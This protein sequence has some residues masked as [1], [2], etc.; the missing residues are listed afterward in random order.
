MVH[1]RNTTPLRVKLFGLAT[2]VGL[3]GGCDEWEN[4]MKT[5]KVTPQYR[6][7]PDS[8]KQLIS[9]IST[10]SSNGNPL[11]LERG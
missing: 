11:S 6:A 10:A 1:R 7:Q 9:Y 8:A 5:E 3:L 4:V 2:V